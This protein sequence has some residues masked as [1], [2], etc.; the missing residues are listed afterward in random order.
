LMACGV[1]AEQAELGIPA[2]GGTDST[3]FPAEKLPTAAFT[4]TYSGFNPWVGQCSN[5]NA[6]LFGREPGGEGK[7]P[8]F[9]YLVGT[10]GIY[11]GTEAAVFVQQMADRGFVAASAEYDSIFGWDAT[12]LD[13]KSRCVFSPVLTTSAVTKLCA[14]A[15]ADCTKGIVVTGFSQGAFLTARSKNHDARVRAAYNIGFNEDLVPASYFDPTAPGP[16]GTRA[17]PADRLRIV[18]GSN[19]ETSTQRDQAKAQLNTLT[20]SSCA[21]SANS[22]LREDGSGWYLVQNSEVLDGVADHCYFHGGGGCSNTPAFDPAWLPPNRLPWSLA[23]NL[24]WLAHHCS[25]GP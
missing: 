7:Y 10:G 14:R 23:T 20:A 25:A 17:L 13:S 15:R 21:L 6:G 12:A 8:V 4:D 22:C 11:N 16:T 2:D 19:I 5:T 24:D 3:P 1:P 18:N 9:V